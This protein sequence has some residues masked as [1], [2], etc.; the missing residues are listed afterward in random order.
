[1]TRQAKQLSDFIMRIVD[2][3]RTKI[4]MSLSRGVIESVND[5][6]GIQVVKLSLLA[7]ENKDKVERF[8]NFGFTSNP[9]AGSEAAIIFVSGN[10]EHGIVVACD[11]RTKRKKSL[12]PGEAAIYT[13]D[14]TFVHLKTGGN[15]EVVASTKVL[16]TSPLVE[17]S[18]NVKV[19]GNIEIIGDASVGGKLDVT[20]IIT[21]SATVLAAGFGG[22][23]GGPMTSTVNIETT[24]N[25]VGGGTN[26]ATIK[27][28]FNGHTHNETGTVTTGP[29]GSV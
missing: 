12:A 14:G 21:G 26:L 28:V 13:S 8:Q 29:S 3:I 25:V 7:G 2:P 23:S 5:A 27:S 10:R 20:G 22:L 19:G 4:I 18:G 1:M 11:D 16:V 24:A 17:F 6:N 15:I 9:P